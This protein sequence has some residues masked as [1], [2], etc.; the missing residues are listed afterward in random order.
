M[1]YCGRVQLIKTE[2]D[3]TGQVRIRLKDHVLKESRFCASDSY[4]DSITCTSKETETRSCCSSS[5]VQVGLPRGISRLQQRASSKVEAW[6]QLTQASRVFCLR[7]HQEMRR[8]KAQAASIRDH[9]TTHACWH[10]DLQDQQDHQDTKLRRERSAKGARWSWSTGRAPSG[11]LASGGH[12]VKDGARPDWGAAAKAMQHHLP[13]QSQGAVQDEADSSIAHDS[14][15]RH[16]RLSAAL[17]SMNISLP[18][19]LA[20]L[21]TR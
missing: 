3:R 6:E 4:A 15:P 11:P 18:G 1:F 9:L 21:R 16:A 10:Q 2:Q 7:V 5:A 20:D 13:A 8:P 12:G 14:S 19:C 17:L